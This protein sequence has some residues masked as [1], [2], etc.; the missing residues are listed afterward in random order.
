M[1]SDRSIVK[2]QQQ[3]QQQN[4]KAIKSGQFNG[5]EEKNVYVD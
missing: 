2:Q 1:P 3:Q 4:R 5:Q